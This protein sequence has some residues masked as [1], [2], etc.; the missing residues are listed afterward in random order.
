[1]M[2]AQ[3]IIALALAAGAAVLLVLRYARGRRKPKFGE[4]ADC[5]A[6]SMHAPAKDSVHS[7]PGSVPG[8]GREPGREP[9][10]GS[11]GNTTG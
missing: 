4:C 10:R 3:Q 8:P 1:M 7:G 2:D 6:A 5:V 11:G 9:G